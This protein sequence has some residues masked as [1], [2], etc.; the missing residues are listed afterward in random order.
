MY[1]YMYFLAQL[2]KLAV[3]VNPIVVDDG[4]LSPFIHSLFA[5]QFLYN[6]STR[7]CSPKVLVPDPSAWTSVN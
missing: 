5:A 3:K 7:G 6:A 4:M 2:R 1:V